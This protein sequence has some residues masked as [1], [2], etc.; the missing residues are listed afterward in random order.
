MSDSRFHFFFICF[1][2]ISTFPVSAQ[3]E[4]EKKL[5]IITRE[6]WGAAPSQGKM[7]PHIPEFITI[8]HTGTTAKPGVS[9]KDKLQ[10]LQKF[11][12][13][14]G[15]LGNGQPKEPWPD[16]PY[17][18]YIASNGSIAEGRPLL[19]EG[20]SNTD[21]DLTGHMLIVLEGNFQE[22][23][24]SNQQFKSLIDLVNLLAEEYNVPSEKITG[25]KDQAPTSCPG[26]NLYELLPLIRK[27]VQPKK[28]PRTVIGA[29]QLFDSEYF[30]LIK[31]KRIG[32]VTNHTGVLP[33][34][35]HLIDKLNEHPQ[36]SLKLL[37]GPEHGLRGEQDTHV[38]NAVD[39]ETGIPII[40]LYGKVRKPASEMLSN[41]DV[42]IFDIQDVGARYY[43]YIKTMLRVQEAAAENNIPLIV[44]DRPNPI[45]A[46]KTAGPVGKSLEPKTEIGIIPVMHGMTV[47]ELALMFNAQRKKNDLPVARQ[48]VIPM[49]NYQRDQ[50]YNQ[51]GLPWIKPSPNML[52]LS[53][54]VVYPGTCLLE[55]T[56]ISEG[57]GTLLPFEQFGAP[58]IDGKIIAGKLNEMDLEGVK[59]METNFVPDSIV[60]GIEIYP[61]KFLGEKVNGV[62]IVVTDRNDFDPLETGISILY[63]LNKTYPEQFKF[64]KGRLDHLLGTST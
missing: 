63:I 11:S 57:R 32:L 49:K 8:H 15:K 21:Y 43:T 60:D 59:F 42:L 44:L 26:K 1:I 19:F 34:G 20:D 30:P 38:A 56:N 61:P 17:H 47:G 18:Y 64:R 14:K 13:S 31:N 22:Q 16:I 45:T 12:F 33:D 53:T 27:Q 36:V 37:F 9:I 54:A 5:N 29:E 39:P 35:T 51:T 55:G 7:I 40:S 50:W 23:Q 6:K 52:R 48:Y 10:A 2:V 4:I 41:I 62:K 46:R 58:W 28:A 3:G 24:L 25:H